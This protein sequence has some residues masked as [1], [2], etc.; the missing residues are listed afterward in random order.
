MKES[1]ITTKR[2]CLAAKRGPGITG[3]L[4]KGF[5]HVQKGLVKESRINQ[6]GAQELRWPAG[7]LA[8]VL[9]GW[10]AG[11]LAGS[12]QKGSKELR[13][14]LITGFSHA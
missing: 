5:L 10:L 6:K 7:W 3:C 13:D 2:G 1:R 4:N 8:G 9:A 12:S 14:S 11:W